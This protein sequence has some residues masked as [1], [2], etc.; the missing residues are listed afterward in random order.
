MKNDQLLIVFV[1][2]IK[3]GKVKTR[4]AKTIGDD[5]AFEVYKHLVEITEQETQQLNNT[6]IHIYFSDKIISEKWQGMEKFVQ[7]G[8][9]LGDRMRNAFDHG[10]QLGYQKIV[11][12]GSDLPDLNHSIIAS[13]FDALDKSET[14]FGPAEDGGYYL[15]GMKQLI[16]Q[17]FENK[18]WSQETL[19]KETLRE[20]ETLNYTTE[21]LQTLND[22]DTIEDLR[23]ST[24]AKNFKQYL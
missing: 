14:V 5:G 23:N 6:T 12:V 24:I 22:V 8:I 10:F 9:T 18:P 1:K 17:I 4:L 7:S 21:L 20:L 3:L 13:G 16:P 19:M 2:N 11:G 15:I